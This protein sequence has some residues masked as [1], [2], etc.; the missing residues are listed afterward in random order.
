[1]NRTV[2]SDSRPIPGKYV[3]GSV[4]M[5]EAIAVFKIRDRCHLGE[6]E[7]LIKHLPFGNL[8][9]GITLPAEHQH[10]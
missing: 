4:N 9:E 7:K 1:M 10:W 3:E 2:A 6:A 5:L 8:A